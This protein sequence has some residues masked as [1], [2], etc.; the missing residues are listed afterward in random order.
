V[1][2]EV[3]I[4]SSPSLYCVLP[5]IT[6]L[7]DELIN[8]EKNEKGGKNCICFFSLSSELLSKE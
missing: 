2:K 7:R 8:G 1:L 5:C 6:Y 3:Q 4:G